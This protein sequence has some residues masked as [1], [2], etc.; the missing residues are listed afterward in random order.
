LCTTI[1][2][3]FVGVWTS[4]IMEKYWGKDPR[5]VVIDEFIGVWIPALIAP[6]G[7]YTWLLALLGFATFRIIDI[8]KPL[9]CRWID[10]NVEGGWGVMLNDALAGIYALIIVLAVK[11]FCI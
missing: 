10:K 1:I 6:C 5:T 9:G 3:T 4:N 8:F 2:V 7:E 11:T